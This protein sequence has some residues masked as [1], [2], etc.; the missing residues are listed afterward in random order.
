M[1]VGEGGQPKKKGDIGK[2]KKK[3]EPPKLKSRMA[4]AAEG[5]NNKGGSDYGSNYGRDYS[6]NYGS[7]YGHYGAYGSELKE[8]MAA[9]EKPDDDP[10]GGGKEGED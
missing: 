10:E 6:N 7:D 8:R 1:G 2:G 5:R 4:P 3:G 9:S